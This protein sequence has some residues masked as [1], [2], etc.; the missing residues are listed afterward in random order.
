MTGSIDCAHDTR[1]ASLR[2]RLVALYA[3]LSAHTEP[4]CSGKCAKPF[5]CCAEKYC[6]F[7]MAFAQEQWNVKLVPTSNAQLPL[8]GSSGCTAAPHLRPM[9]TAH[10]CEICAYDQKR[11]DE[12]WTARYYELMEAISELEAVVLRSG[13]F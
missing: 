2:A 7:A 12:A 9:C 6:G 1:D 11:G 5:S 10:T 8:M 3:E 4:E 13:S